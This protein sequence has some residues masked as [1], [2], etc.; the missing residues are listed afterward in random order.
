MRPT[1][2]NDQRPRDARTGDYLLIA[3]K[4]YFATHVLTKD[5]MIIGREPAC[6]VVI[7]DPELSRQHAVL[8]LGPPMTTSHTGSRPMII[9]SLARTWVAK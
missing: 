5:E 8:R 9:S 2:R 4:G 6:D 1:V 7:D 3:G